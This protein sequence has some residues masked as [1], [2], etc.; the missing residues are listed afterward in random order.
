MTEPFD[1]YAAYYDLFN[2]GKDYDGE[3]EYVQC[4]LNR[5][6]LRGRRVLELGC[7]TGGHA[8]PMCKRGFEVIGVDVSP[9]MLDVARAQLRESTN[10]PI[11]LLEA[12][13]TTLNL[14]ETFDAVVAL[15]H[16]M[17]YQTTD[18]SVEAIV[19]TAA[20]HLDTGGLFLFDYWHGPAVLSQFPEKRY[21]RCEADGIRADRRAEPTVF[22]AEN[23]VRVRY[24]IHV[25]SDTG[26]GPVEFQED[27]NMRYFF[28]P[29]LR[30]FT[31]GAFDWL[32][33]LAWM[34]HTAP[35]LDDWSAVAVLRRT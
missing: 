18:A 2:A 13:V 31:M 14:S 5:N 20:R 4:L 34:K 22:L 12:D 29:E 33:S 23:C 10:V 15:F 7:G 1:A 24:T 16:V 19:D 27:H 26:P 35:G 3:V 17:S 8:L 30:R 11:R 21:K 32:E 25:D 9:R 6:G 28:E